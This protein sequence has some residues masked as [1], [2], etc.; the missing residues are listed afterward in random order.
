[1]SNE[2]VRVQDDLFLYVNGEWLK[3]AVIPDDKPRV[4][5]FSDLDE[6][7]EK[8]MMG[9]Y[10]AWASKEKE[11]PNEVIANSVRLYKKVLDVK[12]R[13]K[14]KMKPI[15]DTLE[16]IL[17]IKDIEDLSNKALECELRGIP[18]P[19]DG[20]VMED[21][22]NATKHCFGITGP[23][24]ILPDTTYY[25]KD[26][27]AKKQLLGIWDAMAVSLVKESPLKK[28]YR[29]VVK[30]ALRFDNKVRKYVKSSEEW[31]DYVKAY[32]PKKC[33]K[34]EE[35]LGKFSL[36]P[37]FNAVYGKA[38]KKIIVADPK[39]I[40]SF[41]KYFNEETFEDYKMWAYVNVLI[42]KSGMLSEDLR[43][44]GGVYQM[45]L[46]GT[47]VLP[48]IEKQ[49]YR[50]AAGIF[51][52]PVGLY[53]G[54]TYFGAEAKKDVVDMV[55]GIIETYKE[56]M[57]NNTFLEE[58][59]REKAILKLNT[60]KIKMGYPDKYDPFF[61]E[62]KVSEKASLCEALSEISRKR[63]MHQLEKLYKPVDKG[64]WAMPGH[65]VNAC[66]DPT[67]NDITFPAA[68]LQKPFYSLSQ[69]RSANLGGIGAV[70]G[71]EISH[72]F[73]NNGARVDENGNLKN[74][75]TE[76]DYENFKAKTKDMIDQ[77]DGLPFAGG[78][79]NG[80]LVV[81]EN[82]AD[83]GGMTVTLNIM[84]KNKASKDDYKEYFENWA[85]VWCVK[86]R[87]Q[88]EQLLL[89]VDVHSPAV[90]RANIQ[91]RNFKEWYETY[92]VKETDNMYI[93]PEKRIIVW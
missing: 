39:A 9:E 37:F 26:N 74:W 48:S 68:I 38:P 32:N 29:Q 80:T 35:Q 53:Y 90:L 42:A 86:S 45:A 4:G 6:G 46:S 2:K 57:K 71:H 91:P 83:N 43:N 28:R 44:K 70:I 3:T 5:G 22:K 13:N 55:Q 18:L 54:E 24:T 21:M 88:Y 58:A 89:K 31:A 79:V 41:T 50:T 47:P 23:S 14:D 17:N 84:E 66:Y 51:A 1:M 16:F 72:A 36:M 34:V 27:P 40:R 20:G 76:K 82:I 30:A 15:L 61:D 73:D 65:M 62:L 69:S 60:M 8:L 92:D 87:P 56:R 59:T 81:S 75:W 63:T 67:A 64:E 19:L 78:Q 11:V 77:F 52:E 49:A 12:K 7:V 25:K 10:N 93:A 85:R 33:E